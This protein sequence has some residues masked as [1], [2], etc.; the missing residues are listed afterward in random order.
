MKVIIDSTFFLGELKLMIM[1]YFKKRIQAES[2]KDY[3]AK[4]NAAELHLYLITSLKTEDPAAF[5]NNI[6]QAGF[7]EAIFL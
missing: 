5:G 1:W 2:W 7:N 3:V 6:G 4:L